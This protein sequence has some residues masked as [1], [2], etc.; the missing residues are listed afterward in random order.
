M[1]VYEKVLSEVK[2]NRESINQIIASSK[3]IAEI[4]ANTGD[5]ENLL[6]VGFNK[7][8]QRSETFPLFIEFQL[9]PKY[10]GKKYS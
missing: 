4:Q 8:K 10:R 7:I 1:S 9:L 3:R 6:V 5:T 2:Q